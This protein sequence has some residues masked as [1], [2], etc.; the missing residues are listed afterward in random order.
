MVA[1]SIGASGEHLPGRRTTIRRL[2]RGGG[3]SRR[4][5]P[6]PM[7][8]WSET[9]QTEPCT[10]GGPRYRPSRSTMGPVTVLGEYKDYWNFEYRYNNPP[11]AGSTLEQYTHADVKGPRLMVT[12]DILK[13]G[14]RLYGSYGDFNTHRDED[15][16][17]G[18][19]GDRALEWYAGVEETAG[20]VYLEASYFSRDWKDRGSPRST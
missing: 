3:R 9:R 2:G 16:L 5:L 12:G 6:T 19:E 13:T 10:E 20:S 18:T 14:T 7:P 1:R 15:S 17:G 8:K 4:G 11:T